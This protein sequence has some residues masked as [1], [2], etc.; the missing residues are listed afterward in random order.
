MS[1]SVTFFVPG[2]PQPF[3]KKRTNKKTGMIYSHD[4][5]GKKKAWTEAIRLAAIA[6]K[7]KLIRKPVAVKFRAAV[8][9]RKPKS[10][11]NPLPTTRPDLDNYM[12]VLHNALQG[13][14]YEDDSQIVHVDEW[15]DWADDSGECDPGMMITITNLEG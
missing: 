4:P 11:K 8:Y 10:N 1:S 5:S 6:A 3:P 13:V 14:C 15:K 7:P 12:Y 9:V 2:D